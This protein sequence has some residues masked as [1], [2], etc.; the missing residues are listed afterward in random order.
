MAR[1][2]LPSMVAVVML[3]SAGVAQPVPG[4][5][6]A[7]PAAAK[8][9]RAHAARSAL[10]PSVEVIDDGARVVSAPTPGAARRGTLG[11]GARLPLLA[12]VR[13]EGCG[14]RGYYQ[15]GEAAYVCAFAVRPSREAPSA[16]GLPAAMPHEYM[17]VKRG[18]AKG[19]VRPQDAATDEYDTAFAQGF[20]VIVQDRAQYDGERF[21][22]TG[23]GYWVRE[24]DLRP[25][26]ASE[27][28]GALLQGAPLSSVAFVT[29]ERT[30]A[31][32]PDGSEREL[33]R[34]SRLSVRA[35]E[36]EQLV[37]DDGSRVPARDCVQAELQ[38]PPEGVAADE[39]W[40]DVDLARQALVAYRGSAPLFATLISSG[41]PRRGTETPRGRFRVWVKLLGS[42]MRDR[43]R[44]ELEQSYALEAVPWVQYFHEGYGLHAAFWHDRFG[45]PMSRGCINLSPADARMLFSLTAPALPS[46]WQAVLPVDRER[47]TLVQVR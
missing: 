32:T 9:T 2:A 20:S 43:E 46:G 17:T 6:R 18:G 41:K 24:R 31:L 12:K 4:K 25:V 3:A 40:L 19:Y 29:A 27:F 47:A 45:E 28:S 11:L 44:H 39:V 33:S 7:H 5:Q 21:V 1:A 14:E 8:L 10:P 22:R 37:L 34:L 26:R 35:R 16:D 23:R 38:P 13:G 30:L 15:V 42:D 36:G